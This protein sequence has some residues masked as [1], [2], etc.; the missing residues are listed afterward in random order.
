MA[1][2]IPRWLVELVP[3]FIQEAVIA[4]MVSAARIPVFIVGFI[5]LVLLSFGLVSVLL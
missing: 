3:D 1:P 4:E 2:V 5:F